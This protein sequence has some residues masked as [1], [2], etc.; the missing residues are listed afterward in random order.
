MAPEK[1]NPSILLLNGPNLNLLGRREPAVYGSATLAEAE[2]RAEKAALQAGLQLECCQ[3]NHEGTLIDC[4]HE[5]M[6]NH[7]GIVINPGAYTHT[8]IALRDALQSVD[9]PAVEV[10]LS[11]IHAREEFRRQSLLA[12][13][14]VGQVCGFGVA[15]YELAI[16]ALAEHIK[17]RGSP[18][19]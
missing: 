18:G 6:D 11:N 1:N 13:V 8:S 5:A 16:R 3:S 19:N 4:I 12:A 9:L 2:E 10:H 15:G 17:K 7:C 14:C